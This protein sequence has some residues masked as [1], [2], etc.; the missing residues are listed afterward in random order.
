MSIE[1]IFYLSC[2]ISGLVLTLQ[3]T[4]FWRHSDRDST[5][6]YWMAAGWALVLSDALFA[7]RPQLPVMPA[8][9]FPTILV[10]IAYLCILWGARKVAG[11]P[12]QVRRATFLVGLQAGGLLLLDYLGSYPNG[13]IIFNR[14][15]WAGF[16][17][18]CF[19][20]LRKGPRPF[21]GS[22]NSPATIL[23]CQGIFYL[24]RAAV[25]VLVTNLG[26][27]NTESALLFIGNMDVILFN[28]A[29]FVAILVALL[30]Q[31]RADLTSTRV[32]METLSGLLPVCAWCKKVRDDKGYW[33][34]ITEYF[35]RKNSLQITHGICQ[36]CSSQLKAET[37]V[38][39]E[40]RTGTRGLPPAEE[41]LP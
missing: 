4:H 18:A 22:I 6:A 15:V 17:L 8:R 33:S 14:L 30:L 24:V 10:T 20:C 32:E 31:Q 41:R 35:A 19:V 9:L 39:R 21:W 36:S 26:W 12:L 5:F 29:L 27:K 3:I 25:G 23:L 11:L 34:E 28:T 38:A 7:L 40:T 37:G 2:T 13:R 16:C 1:T